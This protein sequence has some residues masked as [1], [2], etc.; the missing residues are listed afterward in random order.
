MKKIRIQDAGRKLLAYWKS[1]T[2]AL[3][4]TVIAATG[5]YFWHKNNKPVSPGKTV[6]VKRGL[7][8]SV[9]QATGSVAAT[10][11]VDIS[12]KIT[13]RVMEVRVNENDQ[14]TA[15]QIVI[16]L[17]DSHY[18]AL[19]E[20]ARS[21]LDVSLK[22]FERLKRLAAVG[23]IAAK[24]LEQG[25]MEWL[26]AENDY[27][28]AASQ[29]ADTVIR[30]PINGTV[31]GKPIPAGQ[32]VSSGL[33]NPMVLMT[34]ADLS[35]LELQVL[36]DEAD[37]GKLK[38]MQKVGFMVDSFPKKMFAGKITT[39]SGKANVQQN[40]VYYPVAISLDKPEEGFKPGMTVRVTVVAG[41]KKDV[42][43]VPAVAIA[44]KTNGSYVKVVES[45]RVQEKMIQKGMVGT[46]R[47]E[48][49][50]GLQEGDQ[51]LLPPGS[52]G[53]GMMGLPSMGAGA[54]HAH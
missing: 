45:E 3:L 47:V 15:G 39:I 26:V 48:V 50:S 32:S 9:V 30:S 54:G 6:T 49:T 21:R 7:I 2:I 27:N 31:V 13:G 25:K 23:G 14:V 1:M 16:V 20:K 38:V 17:D 52:K 35:Q 36:V 28:I 10:H 18:K 19:M 44:T 12:A 24:E 43:T 51:V 42:L 53:G 40:V 37:I 8:R 34:I 46:S 22:N 5:C 29:L 11:S 33:S 41:Q 4:V